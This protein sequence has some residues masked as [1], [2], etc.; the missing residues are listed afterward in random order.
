MSITE[1]KF[2]FTIYSKKTPK[3]RGIL[4]IKIQATNMNFHR[5]DFIASGLD[6]LLYLYIKTTIE[7]FSFCKMA[8]INV[9]FIN[10]S[11]F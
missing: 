3:M 7:I 4:E 9:T 5:I 6:T 2:S 8:N 11:F 1:S 10:F